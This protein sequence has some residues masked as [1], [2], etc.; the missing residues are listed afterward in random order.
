MAT[1]FSRRMLHAD[2]QSVL[3]AHVQGVLHKW[4]RTNYLLAQPSGTAR[5]DASAKPQ[6]GPTKASVGT[7]CDGCGRPGHTHPDWN[8]T[9]APWRNSNAYQLIYESNVTRSQALSYP[10]CIARTGRGWRRNEAASP[11]TSSSTNK[12]G[13]GGNNKGGCGLIK[14]KAM[15]TDDL[16]SYTGNMSEEAKRVC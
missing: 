14:Y 13:S 6:E 1:A 12:Y 10:D 8:K 7:H 5:T 4:E 2:V 15:R 9:S 16:L 11:P 3:G